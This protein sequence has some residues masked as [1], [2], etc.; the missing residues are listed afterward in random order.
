VISGFLIS[1]IIIEQERSNSFSYADFYSRRVRRI[2]P[3]FVIIYIG[4]S[5]SHWQ[6]LGIDFFG[7][8]SAKNLIS[9]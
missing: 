9:C 2:F 7:L 3:E 1:R 8:Q 6:R 4:G 5:M